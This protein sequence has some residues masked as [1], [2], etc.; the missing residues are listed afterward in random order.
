MSSE[1][2]RKRDALPKNA[3]DIASYDPHNPWLIVR[4]EGRSYPYYDFMYLVSVCLFASLY[5][6]WNLWVLCLRVFVDYET[7][8]SQATAAAA[9]TT[10]AGTTATNKAR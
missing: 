2:L 3:M 9:G 10:A 6:D 7:K 8:E 1:L 5:L 4:P